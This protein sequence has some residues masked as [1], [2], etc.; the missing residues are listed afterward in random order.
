MRLRTEGA[1]RLDLAAAVRLAGRAHLV[2]SCRLMAVRAEAQPRRRDAVLGAALVAARLRRF[3]LGDCHQRPRSI[4]RTCS[5]SPSTDS[6]AG[7]RRPLRGMRRSYRRRLL[8]RAR[9][10]GWRSHA[11]R[12]TPPSDSIRIIEA[13]ACER[14]GRGPPD[15]GIGTG[16]DRDGHLGECDEIQ[17]VP[18]GR[19]ARPHAASSVAHVPTG[20][21]A[22]CVL[23][24]ERPSHPGDERY[25]AKPS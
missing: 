16:D 23:A 4:A 7:S 13:V 15:A 24:W 21:R 19:A 22:P 2:R 25:S 12:S 11:H 9:R 20:T 8:S 1:E 3:S 17:S 10:S 5:P 6:S 18:P 14:H